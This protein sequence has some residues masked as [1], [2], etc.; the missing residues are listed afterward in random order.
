MQW[1]E[2]RKTYDER[3]NT[4]T[5]NSQVEAKKAIK[6]LELEIQKRFPEA[7]ENPSLLLETEWRKMCSLFS[8]HGEEATI[9]GKGVKNRTFRALRQVRTI[10][11]KSHNFT[12]LAD[13]R[14]DADATIFTK[15]EVMYC[16][17]KWLEANDWKKVKC[18]YDLS[19]RRDVFAEKNGQSLVAVALSSVFHPDWKNVMRVDANLFKSNL[20][21]KFLTL[22]EELN[23]N[24]KVLAALIFAGDAASCETISPFVVHLKKTGIRVFAIKSI[25]KVIEL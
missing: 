4:Y 9:Y 23:S 1:S 2:I 3:V 14:I 12:N 19:A 24:P 15:T 7:W 25:S 5:P 13:K 6:E 16:F 17:S 21:R 20:S 22:L 8:A 11:E 18:M 10:L